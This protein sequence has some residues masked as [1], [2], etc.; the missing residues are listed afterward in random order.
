MGKK[1]SNRKKTHNI[2]P[3]F[4]VFP[5]PHEALHWWRE[6]LRDGFQ[7]PGAAEH[8]ETLA[9]ESDDIQHREKFQSLGNLTAG[10]LEQ[11]GKLKNHPNG[12]S[13]FI[14]DHES[15]RMFIASGTGG[16]VCLELTSGKRLWTIESER[17]YQVGGLALCDGTLYY[18]D[19]WRDKL[20]AVCCRTGKQ[21]WCVD[22][23]GDG[24]PLLCPA[25]V[26]V[27]HGSSGNLLLVCDSGNHR[28]CSFT[29]DAKP[30]NAYGRRGLE[31]ERI[32]QV[33]S[34]PDDTIVP[35]YFEYPKGLTVAHNLD[36]KE[37]LYVWDSGNGRLVLLDNERDHLHAIRIVTGEKVMLR[38]AGQVTVLAGPSGP[39]I[40]VIDDV[41]STLSLRGPLGELL[42]TVDLSSLLKSSRRKLEC[43]R[44]DSGGCSDDG[45]LLLSSSGA[46]WRIPSD[47]LDVER[48]TTA[49]LP[50]YPEDCRLVLANA[51]F[52]GSNI[53]SAWQDISPV[54]DHNALVRGLLD[55]CAI[56]SDEF[57]LAVE[58]LGRLVQTLGANSSDNDAT[59][60]EQ[61]L[62]S[63]LDGYRTTTLKDMLSHARPSPG[64]I[65]RW[66]DAQAEVDMELFQ[67]RG[68]KS[69]AELARDEHLEQVREL[70][71]SIRRLG[72]QLRKLHHLL[73]PRQSADWLEGIA[74]GLLNELESSL[75]A[76]VRIIATAAK[77][78][79]YERDPQ[80]VAREE[81][82]AA[83]AA[84]LCIS[85]LDSA[86][87]VLAG[88]FSHLAS[89]YPELLNTENLEK[90]TKLL[91]KATGLECSDILSKIAGETTAGPEPFE[92]L[93]DNELFGESISEKIRALVENMVSYLAKVEGSGSSG[94]QF[95]KVLERQRNLFA[96]KASV[97]SNHSLAGEDYH[98]LLE[99]ARTIAGE[100]W[101]LNKQFRFMEPQVE[102]VE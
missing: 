20:Y 27:A 93:P 92:H 18:T 56:L 73:T 90:V 51:G 11:A 86:A 49:L 33:H 29:P 85:V 2:S 70:R 5:S 38:L 9:G 62:L 94:G 26:A 68:S 28:I 60:L 43:F 21:N 46:M 31:W 35:P 64:E 101:N 59:A 72:W 40:A 99:H 13:A 75:D 41:L 91:G 12:L 15:G 78:L 81:I 36:G 32:T 63:R 48:L 67:S 55:D 82:Q 1:N 39:L 44:L 84:M 3:A 42:L 14:S 4:P 100:A 69:S 22:K 80:R 83:H 25:G 77:G 52:T 45:V 37:S 19:S 95:G 96:L 97:L 23:T 58:R 57:S 6:R 66:S 34:A 54:Q 102:R 87:V 79:D 74:A 10:V 98:T 89:Q 8:L 65:E 61:A 17:A 76:R 50:L 30:L 16:I 71:P 88:E 7:L 53:G 47:A 24:S